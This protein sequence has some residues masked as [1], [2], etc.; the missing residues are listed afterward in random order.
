M[1]DLSQMVA[2]AEVYESDVGQLATW[3]RSAPIPADVTNPALPKPL[4][5]TVRS[6]A[7]I[8]RMIARNQVF[9]MGPREDADRR[10]V[11]VVVHL[12]PADAAAAS[13]FVGLQVTVAFAPTK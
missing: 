7:D 8:S 2:V 1:G 9:A 11:E 13:R 5:G 12:N 10:V 4:K 6:E 3:V